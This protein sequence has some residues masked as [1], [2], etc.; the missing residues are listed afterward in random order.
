MQPL[1][2]ELFL[3]KAEALKPQ[4]IQKEHR[5][6]RMVTI[7]KNSEGFGRIAGERP[8]TELAE[9]DM[10]GL[11]GPLCGIS[12]PAPVFRGE[13]SRCAALYEA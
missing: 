8:I 7:E 12:Y 3:E 13:H 11:W 4:L 10:P 1:V 9:Y 5:P 2:N 6:L